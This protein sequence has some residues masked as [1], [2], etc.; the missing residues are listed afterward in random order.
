MKAR[1][2]RNDEVKRVVAFIPRG[3][4]HVRLLLELEDQAIILSEATLAA[5]TRAYLS[6]LLHPLRRAVEMRLVRLPERKALYAEYQ[7][8]ETGRGE[9]EVL[10]EA[11]E[12]WRSAITGS[13]GAGCSEHGG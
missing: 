4:A 8:L 13:D 12:V 10:A 2:Y 6:V 9:E 3:H 5:V 7:L 11:E 1:V